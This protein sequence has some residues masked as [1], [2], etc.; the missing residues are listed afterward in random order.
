VETTFRM[1]ILTSVSIFR[2]LPAS[3]GHFC[4]FSMVGFVLFQLHV[5]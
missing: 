4:S 1:A 3:F 2:C 5:V